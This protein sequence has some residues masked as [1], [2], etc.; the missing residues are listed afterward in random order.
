M[1]RW[2]EYIFNEGRTCGDG[3]NRVDHY[4]LNCIL[5]N[6]VEISAPVPQNVTL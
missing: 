6:D 5:P 2:G 1:L 4:G 3:G